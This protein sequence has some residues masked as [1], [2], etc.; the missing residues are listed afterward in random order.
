MSDDSGIHRFRRSGCVS[1]LPVHEERAA[2]TEQFDQRRNGGQTLGDGDAEP[3]GV[4]PVVQFTTRDGGE[5]F[6][7]DLARGF[8]LGGFLC[9]VVLSPHEWNDL[10]FHSLLIFRITLQSFYK[11]L[12]FITNPF[13]DNRDIQ[14]HY[15]EGD[16]RAKHQ[17]HR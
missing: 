4:V 11:H 8:D 9:R 16:D 15:A 2:E 1:A 14:Q 10:V 13:R 17:R 3:S 6:V 5:D 12:F 7:G